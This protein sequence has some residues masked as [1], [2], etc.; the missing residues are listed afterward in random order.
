MTMMTRRQAGRAA[1]TAGAL[2]VLGGAVTVSPAAAADDPA[3]R[4]P[5][6]VGANPAVQLFD[7]SGACTA[8]VSCWRVDWSVRGSGTAV[9]FWRP[10]GVTV[11]GRDPELGGWLAE[12]FVRHFPELEGLP[13]S[14]PAFERCDAH[15]DVD[16]ARGMRARAGQVE[17]TVADVLDRRSYTTDGF[18]LAGVPHS[19]HLVLAPCRSGDIRVAGRALRG[20]V[21]F[22]GTPE[23]PGSSAFVTEA[24]VWRAP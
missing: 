17:V 15:L 5:I 19:L 1:L 6:L 18:E 4:S 7:S 24:E 3:T 20:T 16:L 23:R 8:Y 10:D 2:A 9:V 12:R 11:L 13:W 14:P 21:D 22:W